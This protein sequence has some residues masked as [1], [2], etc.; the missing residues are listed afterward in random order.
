MVCIDGIMNNSEK[1]NG[2]MNKTDPIIPLPP[3]MMLCIHGD[4][5]HDHDHDHVSS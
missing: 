5:D 3:P 1:M 4:H 2:I